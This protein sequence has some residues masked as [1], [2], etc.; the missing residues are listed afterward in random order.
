MWLFESLSK[1]QWFV[2]VTVIPMHFEIWAENADNFFTGMNLRPA[3]Y[4]LPNAA[5]LQLW[6]ST[7][8]FE[9]KPCD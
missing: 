3:V 5:S 6:R 9:T 8:D 7:F 4:V 1:W 2:R